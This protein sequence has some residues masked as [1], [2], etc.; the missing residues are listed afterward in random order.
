LTLISLKVDY[1]TCF[2]FLS[3]LPVSSVDFF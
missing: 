2:L 3:R 1:S